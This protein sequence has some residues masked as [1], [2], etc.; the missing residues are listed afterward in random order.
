[1][2][3]SVILPAAGT[4]SR[5]DN[6]EKKQFVELD[7]RTVWQRTVELFCT[8]EDVCQILM[9]INP[10]DNEMVRRRFAANLA[11]MNVQLVDG[12]KERC[13]SVEN[14]LGKVC[15]EAT[16]VAIHDAVRPCA[17]PQQIDSVFQ[18]A[19]MHGA[20][21]LATP[22]VHTL[23][24]EK[25]GGAIAET[26]PRNGLWLAQTPQVFA[27]EVIREAYRNRKEEFFPTDDSQMVETIG[28]SVQ[29]VPCGLENLKITTADDLRL[30]DCILKSR[31][32]P[33]PRQFHPFADEM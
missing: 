14:A 15:A 12:G 20:A 16:H 17:T 26:L 19:L 9:V 30:A 7:G 8:R 22:L 28:Q 18:A 23:K 6:R 31:P 21:I 4:S 5:F 25:G 10:D 24:K 13:I 1:M 27:K 29:L 33:K 2:K 11:F 3:V 32:K